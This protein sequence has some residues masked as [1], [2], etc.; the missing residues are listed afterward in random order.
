[1]ND[2]RHLRTLDLNLLVVFD[3]VYRERHV[4]R[5]AEKLGMSQPA[6]SNAL[7]RLRSALDDELLVKSPVGMEPT[8]RAKELAAPIQSILAELEDILGRRQFDPATD[9][10]TVTLAAVDYF[11]LVLLPPL[12]RFLSHHAPHMTLRVVPTS[13][14][15]QELLDLGE[16]DLVLAS[17]GDVPTRFQK[18]VLAQEGYACILRHDHPILKQ[19]LTPKRYAQL[20]HVLHNPG[21]DPFGSTDKAL[22]ALGYERHIAL[23]V[24]SFTHAESI[25]ATTDMILTAP[26]GVAML[27]AQSPALEIADC[28]VAVDL[29]AQQLEMLSH[30]RRSKRPLVAWVRQVIS[31]IAARQ[32]ASDTLDL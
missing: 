20:R 9:T 25:I 17:F 3:A 24:N 16:V 26:R 19:G 22:A 7:Q 27:L 32:L 14:R 8:D 2:K 28:P 5:A 23:T 4:T 1:M 13:G 18:D 6:M 31:D 29:S 12:A 11:N 21:K 10:G 30:S 15:S